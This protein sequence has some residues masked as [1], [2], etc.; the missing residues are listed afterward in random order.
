MKGGKNAR[1]EERKNG[2]S[3]SS[4]AVRKSRKIKENQKI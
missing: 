3:G 2:S 1:M 4:E